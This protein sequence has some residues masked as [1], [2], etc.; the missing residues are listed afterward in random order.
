MRSGLSIHYDSFL[1]ADGHAEA[2]AGLSEATTQFLQVCLG[3]S[4]WSRASSAYSSSRISTRLAL[5]L[6]G[7]RERLNNLPLLRVWS[8]TPSTGKALARRAEKR[9]RTASGPAKAVAR[10]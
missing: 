8:M 1:Q 9:G 7:S 4:N 6:A 2:S 5:V 10:F 3:V